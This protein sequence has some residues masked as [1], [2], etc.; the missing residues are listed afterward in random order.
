MGK[1]QKV[2]KKQIEDYIAFLEKALKSDNFKNNNPTEY[3][4]YKVKLANERLKLKL[5]FNTK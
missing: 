3:E 4:K 2:T 1:Q 5:L